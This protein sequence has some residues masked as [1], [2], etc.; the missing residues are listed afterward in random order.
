MT[1]LRGGQHDCLPFVS[2]VTRGRNPTVTMLTKGRTCWDVIFVLSYQTTSP[3]PPPPP[4]PP[5]TPPPPLPNPTAH[6]GA[7]KILDK[8]KLT[9]ITWPGQCLSSRFTMLTMLTYLDLLSFKFEELC[10]TVDLSKPTRIQ[11]LQV[12]YNS[13]INILSIF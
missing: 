3:P 8:L 11:Y 2:I 6:P 13:T 7:P 12:R 9:I 10:S 5:P 1:S 4:P